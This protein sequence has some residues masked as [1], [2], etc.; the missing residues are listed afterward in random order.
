MLQLS[1]HRPNHSEWYQLDT[2]RFPSHIKTE[3]IYIIW[4]SGMRY[5]V[6]CVDVGQG[7]IGPRITSHQ[8][9]PGILKYRMHGTLRF[10]WAELQAPLRDGVERYLAN[11]LQPLAGR[12][13]PD[14]APIPVNLPAAA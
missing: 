7:Q 9:D 13:Y 4:I 2:I 14:A 11:R 10:T 8:G 5:T 1:W 12:R 3:G 6:P